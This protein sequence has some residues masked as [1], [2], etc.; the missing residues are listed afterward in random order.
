MGHVT[1]TPGQTLK[2]GAKCPHER[3]MRRDV[4]P[5]QNATPKRTWKLQ[6]ALLQGH[7][8]GAWVFLPGQAALMHCNQSALDWFKKKKKVKITK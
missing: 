3:R 8:P 4:A 1:P 2:E 6:G 7:S 5:H